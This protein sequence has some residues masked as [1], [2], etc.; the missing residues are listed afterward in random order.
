LVKKAGKF[1]FID[2]QGSLRIPLKYDFATSFFYGITKVR[3]GTEWRYLD[4][5]GQCIQNCPS[6]E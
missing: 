2:Q 6:G 3:L 4:L 5:N 1:G